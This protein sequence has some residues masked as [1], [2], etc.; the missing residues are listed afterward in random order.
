[1][2]S[3]LEVL[4]D[5]KTCGCWVEQVCDDLLIDLQEAA[6]A[7]EA[8]LPPFSLQPLTPCGGDVSIDLHEGDASCGSCS[9]LRQSCAMW[10]HPPSP[11]VGITV[12]Q[13]E[14]IQRQC[15]KTASLANHAMR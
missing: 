9:T 4:S 6:L 5:L 3:S 2:D 10:R 13:G 1:M 8:H 14:P 11:T 15:N 7:Q 12:R